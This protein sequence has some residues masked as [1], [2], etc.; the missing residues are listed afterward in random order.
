[1]RLSVRL[2]AAMVLLAVLAAASVAALAYFRIEAEVA[3]ALAVRDAFIA[4][5]LVAV[6]LAM[7]IARSLSRPLVQTAGAMSAFARG[8]PIQA[9]TTAGGEIGD[10]A[11]AFNRMAAEVSEKTASVRRNA[12]LLDKTVASAGEPLLVIDASGKTI[13][14]N[15][16]FRALF[17]ERTDFGSPEWRDRL[18]R[19]RSDGVTPLPSGETPIGRA[20]KGESFDDLEV[21]VRR[22]GEQVATHILATGRPTFDASGRLEGAVIIYR[23]QTQAKETERQLHQAQKMDAIGQLTG[24]VAHDFNNIL[25]VITGVAEMLG[26]RLGGQPDEAALARMI[27]QAADRGASLTQHLLAFARRQVLAPVETDVNSLIAD[28][29]K[30]LRPTLGEHVEIETS[31]ARGLPAALIDPSQLTTALLNLALNARDAMPKGGKL[32]IETGIA[33][34][35]EAYAQANAEVAPGDY[36][37]VAVSDTGAG[38]P[39][40][41]RDKVFEPFFTTKEAGKGTGL[42]LSMVYGFMKQSGGHAKIYSEE[43]HGTTV[44]LYLP[45]A[46]P[47]AGAAAPRATE[48][49]LP[50]G[51]EV[52]LVVEDDALVRA[53]VVK[54]LELL[55]YRTIAAATGAEALAIVRK[56][57]AF[58]LLFTDIVMPGG[59]SGRQLAEAVAALRPDVKV[60]YTSRATPTTPSSITEGS[61]PA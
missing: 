15:P 24:G 52:V 17:G 50:R 34:L 11:R 44:K 23:D 26:E 60:L 30:L 49:P 55:G 4:A 38:I 12:E 45:R 22:P 47:G 31:L 20:L 3:P 46:Q 14:T 41:I 8:E 10:L 51:S 1:M 25:T 32:T 56:G 54:R 39:A 59:M 28:A 61:I 40:A 35:D 16:A 58:D 19:F 18:R 57:D 53:N 7:L 6:M 27:E 48:A 33:T 29:T 21:I 43:G 5:G 42:G 13:L 2:M 37:V 9:P 36:V